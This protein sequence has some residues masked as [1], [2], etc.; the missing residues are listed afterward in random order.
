[1]HRRMGE[2]LLS[3]GLIS[4][5]Q[6]SAALSAQ[7]TSDKRLGQI[8]VEAGSISEEQLLDVL[9]RQMGVDSVDLSGMVIPGE[10]AEFVP[11]DVARGRSAVPFDIRDDRLYVAMIDPQDHAAVKEIEQ[12]A[13][14]SVVPNIASERMVKGAFYALYGHEEAADIIS[15]LC[16]TVT[17]TPYSGGEPQYEKLDISENTALC[18]K[19][20]NL[21][22]IDACIANASDIHLEPQKTDMQV[23]IR[24]DGFLHTTLRIPR[25]LQD[26]IISRLKIMGRMDISE[27]RTPQDGSVTVQLGDG[28]LD[29]RISTIPIIYGEKAVIRILDSSSRLTDLRSLGMEGSN[30]EKC[31]KLLRCSSGITMIVGPTGSGKSSTMRAMIRELNNDEINL[32]TLEDP[33]EYHISGVNQIQIN[34]KTGLT[35]AAGLRAILRQDPDVIA[36]GEIRDGDTAKIAMQAAV[37]GHMVLTTIH[38]SDTASSIDRLCSMGVEPYIIAEALRG[39]I[40]Q[41]LV[42]RICPD[43]RAAY[44]ASAQELAWLGLPEGSNVRLWR[45]SGCPRCYHTGYSGRTGIFEVLELNAEARQLIAAGYHSTDILPVLENQGFQDLRQNGIQL[46]LDGVTTIDE[47]VRVL[48]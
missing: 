16:A 37:T 7:E 6:L 20:V 2:L 26:M 32:V 30:L 27:H 47:V 34:E 8:L 12:A 4:R 46:V 21:I 38:T 1:M 15:R 45:G 19:L 42:R 18:I 11:L 3:D 48:S 44:T 17:K 13:S 41:R 28:S 31:M 14:M 36:V 9:G 5:E 39:V 40:S 24:V 23:R 33:V 10:L 35:F 22:I 25:K 43:C 29:L